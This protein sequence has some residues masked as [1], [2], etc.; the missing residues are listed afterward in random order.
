MGAWHAIYGECLKSKGKNPSKSQK[1]A[2]YD[3]ATRSLGGRGG[4]SGGK[5]R[6]MARRC[7]YG[8]LKRRV[9]TPSG[10]YRVCKKKPR[11]AKAAAPRRRPSRSSYQRNK[12]MGPCQHGRLVSPVK[13]PGG[14]T[15]FCKLP[16]R[17]S[18]AAAASMPASSG[19]ATQWMP[20]SK[21]PWL[22][23][24]AAPARKQIDERPRSRR[25][26][27]LF[28]KWLARNERP[29][30]G[31]DGGW[32]GPCQFGRLQKPV[33]ENGRMRYCK[34]D[35]SGNLFQARTTEYMPTK[36]TAFPRGWRPRG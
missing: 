9:K 17:V 4:R 31:A 24:D 14:G 16:P 26:G 35:P 11:T 33:M 13:L 29:A 34:K 6:S 30:A 22:E 10:G 5:G 23:A 3:Q 7:K 8:K 18:Q 15:R 12:F 27:G 28:D 2:C 20:P 32:Q 1:S 25:G 36:T 21:A 19:R